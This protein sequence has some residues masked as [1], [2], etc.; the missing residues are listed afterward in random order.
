MIQE[1]CITAFKKNLDYF[2]DNYV[3]VYHKIVNF[4]NLIDEKDYNARY[5]LEYID[6]KFEL[7]HIKSNS[8]FYDKDH[9]VFDEKAVS[10]SDFYTNQNTIIPI[11]IEA[12]SSEYIKKLK[13]QRDN[14]DT[15]KTI[16]KLRTLL[17]FV[18]NDFEKKEFN[19]IYKFM[20]V[21]TILGTHLNKLDKKVQSSNY[22]IIEPD[23]EIFYLSMF[24]TKYYEFAQNA[25][26]LYSVMDKDSELLTKL[27]EFQNIDFNKNY[28]I[29]YHIATNSY[30]YIL[31]TVSL[32]LSS[33]NPLSYTYNSFLKNVKRTI[34]HISH[35]SNILNFNACDSMFGD[36]P[37]L[38]VSSGPSVEKHI[39]W[40]KK[41]QDRFVVVCFSQMLK[42]LVS[43]S[44][45]PDI[46]TMIDAEKVMY[47]HF[48]IED[49]S[50]IKNSILLATTNVYPKILKLFKK[51]KI[52][53]FEKNSCLKKNAM[54]IIGNT[55]GEITYFLL[56][57]LK[58]E[59]IYLLGT[60]LAVD[61]AGRTHDS[62][63]TSNQLKKSL[64]VKKIK[65]V[66]YDQKVKINQEQAL[67]EVEG[68]FGGIV[69]TTFFFR[70]YI[71]NYNAITQGYKQRSQNVYNLSDGAKLEG[72]KS[73]SKIDLF[74]K[75]KKINKTKLSKKLKNNFDIISE[76]DTTGAE[77]DFIKLEIARINKIL[78]NELFF[79]FKISNYE[80]FEE[81][82]N[83]LV[84]LVLRHHK[85]NY[86]LMCFYICYNYLQISCNFIDYFLNDSNKK[87][88]YMKIYEIFI[89]QVRNILKK[90]QKQCKILIKS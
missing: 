65:V 4:K 2:K 44:I 42:R 80:E 53:L 54:A 73:F 63:H 15:I 33:Q 83:H 22:M 31:E 59:N 25:N 10:S 20:F 26:K 49:K 47:E 5:S 24:V 16:E 38:I 67:I 39:K 89:G 66:D 55:V 50:R 29:K 85:N 18:D 58:A 12:I 43:E 70:R 32:S 78:E 14:Q 19:K 17:A 61:K 71:S 3:D 64:K 77:K 75:F 84:N 57:R 27:N 21:G 30:N 76:Y 36:K 7:L 40:L 74:K 8:F 52:Y 9:L 62:S 48:K 23:I 46:I 37:V 90:Y 68:N 86:S 69:Y 88:D 72:I 41:Y 35:N 6:K 60:D 87:Y 45:I 11:S 34:P 51:E 28:C 81:K 1:Q 56:V 79:N 82:T 13:K